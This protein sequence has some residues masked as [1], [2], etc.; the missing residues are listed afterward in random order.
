MSSGR[1]TLQSLDRALS[2]VRNEF[3]ALDSDLQQVS[4]KLVSMRRREAALYRSLALIRLGD[5]EAREF[6]AQLDSADRE[7]DQCLKDR[8]VEQTR[9]NEKML[10]SRE[11]LDTLVSER[12]SAATRL[13]DAETALA[14]LLASVD[15]D[16]QKDDSYLGASAATQAAIDMAANAEGKASQAETDRREK[17][18]PYQADELFMYLWDRGYG[19]SEYK[20][21]FFA[22]FMDGMVARHLRYETARRNYSMLN[23]IPRRLR[24]HTERL[25]QEAAAKVEA[26]NALERAAEVAAGIENLE[27]NRDTCQALCVQLDKDIN[28]AE[29]AYAKM[30]KAREEFSSGKDPWFTK[31]MDVLV[32]NFKAEPI[33][34]L[35]EEAQATRGYEDDKQVQELAEL[36]EDRAR[37]QQ[38]FDDRRELHGRRQGRLRDLASVRERYKGRQFDSVDSVIDDRGNIE[39]MLGEFL[40]GLISSDRL[41]SSIR[42]SQRFRKRHS[43]SGNRGGAFG[44]IRIP[45]MPR[46]VRVPRGMGGSGGFKAPRLPRGGFSTKGR[47]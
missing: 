25:E 26:L 12:D 46:G 7:A 43:S 1:R 13:A 15:A 19:T 6:T 2:Q 3:G 8:E 21:G 39:M 27:Q 14:D 33:P 35:R 4:T 9:L 34:Q 31:A 17:G 20:A 28:D 24:R 16:L 45:K 30:L 10:Q 44:G 42:H 22:R 40:R 36:R 18:K 29:T 41:W 37:L 11:A 32:R 23:E 38:Q 5:L 47:F